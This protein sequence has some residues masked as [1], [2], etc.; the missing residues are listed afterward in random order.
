MGVVL[1]HDWLRWDCG[2]R[3]THW[4]RLPGM[5]GSFIRLR[6]A[7]PDMNERGLAMFPWG[8]YRG[9]SRPGM[10]EITMDFHNSTAP[11]HPYYF[12]LYTEDCLLWCLMKYV[13]PACGCCAKFLFPPEDHRGTKKH[14]NKVE[15]M[16][17]CIESQAALEKLRSEAAWSL[18]AKNQHGM[19][20]S[21][22]L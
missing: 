22:C 15:W 14:Y 8:N 10:P 3:V 16:R 2:A 13:W 17:C 12:S 6:E 11:G 5:R 18:S 1:G 4:V 7:R 9:I 20:F 21:R 19:A